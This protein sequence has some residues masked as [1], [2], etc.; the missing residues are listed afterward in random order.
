ASYGIGPFKAYAGCK[1]ASSYFS[2]PQ[3]RDERYLDAGV[4]QMYIM[5][6]GGISGQRRY[7]GTSFPRMSSPGTTL[8]L[9]DAVTWGGLAAITYNSAD[10]AH[11]AQYGESAVHPTPTRVA[12]RHSDRANLAFYDGHVESLTAEEVLAHPEFWLLEH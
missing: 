6:Y 9:A 10:P 2:N 12:Y 5:A 8:F 1:A 7:R 4:L 3:I 11:Y